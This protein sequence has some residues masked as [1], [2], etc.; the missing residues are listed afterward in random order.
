METKDWIIL[1]VPHV[2]TVI[3]S[4]LTVFLNNMIQKKSNRKTRI[5]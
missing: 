2:F 5:F 3:F 4:T 1:I